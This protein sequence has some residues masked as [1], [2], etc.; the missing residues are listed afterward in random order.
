MKG[1]VSIIDIRRHTFVDI[2]LIES[3]V[4]ENIKLKIDQ[5][6]EQQKESVEAYL[7][8]GNIFND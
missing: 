3:K 7:R 1:F 5:L 2:S 6:N 8:G 4:N